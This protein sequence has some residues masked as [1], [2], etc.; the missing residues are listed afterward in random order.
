VKTL[1][2]ISKSIKPNSGGLD[3]NAL[4]DAQKIVDVKDR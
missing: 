2:E 3:K 1:H 4:E